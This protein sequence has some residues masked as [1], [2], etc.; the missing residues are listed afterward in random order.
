[1]VPT[2]QKNILC[3]M[4]LVATIWFGFA[5][6]NV[7]GMNR[8]EYRSHIR[9]MEITQ[10]PNRFGHFYGNNVRRIHRFRHGR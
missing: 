2:A 3:S 6:S 4:A 5:A 1:M 7:Q 8:A 9:S 10:R